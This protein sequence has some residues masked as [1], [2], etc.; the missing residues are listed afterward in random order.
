M[1]CRLLFC[2]AVR[3]SFID[4]IR[5]IL[6]EVVVQGRVTSEEHRGTSD[7]TGLS[8]MLV[9][10]LHFAT[11]AGILQKLQTPFLLELGTRIGPKLWTL[12][13]DS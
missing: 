11:A 9:S 10:T 6:V 3:A 5:F 1:V 8:M 12:R 13:R 2:K 7:L 4:F